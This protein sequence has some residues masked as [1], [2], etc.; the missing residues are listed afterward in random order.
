MEGRYRMIQG[1]EEAVLWLQLS[2][3]LTVGMVGDLRKMGRGGGALGKERGKNNMRLMKDHHVSC[4]P[5][6]LCVET[7]ESGRINFLVI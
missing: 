1:S 6:L 4:P 7:N 5:S 2:E 3:P